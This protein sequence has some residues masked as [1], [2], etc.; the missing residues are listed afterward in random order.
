[1]NRLKFEVRQPLP[2]YLL[3]GGRSSRFGSDKALAL[4]N[5]VPLVRRVAEQFEAAERAMLVADDAEKYRQLGFGTI[6]DSVAGRGPLGGLLAACEHQHSEGWFWL[7][8]CDTL[9]TD[10]DAPGRLMEAIGEGVQVVAFRA[11]VWEP[12]PA[13]YHT[14]ILPRLRQQLAAGETAIWRLI[15]KVPHAPVSF[16]STKPPILHINTPRDLE[17]FLPRSSEQA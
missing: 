3:A 9:F 8:G 4:V 6:P 7:S 11:E 14:T 17:S 13:L 12:M 10:A 2:V 15:D 16:A 1:V 5:G